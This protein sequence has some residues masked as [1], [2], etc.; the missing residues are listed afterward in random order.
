MQSV[1]FVSLCKLIQS[2]FELIELINPATQFGVS[3]K[4][5]SRIV[6][7]VVLSTHRRMATITSSCAF[8]V[9][10]QLLP[11]GLGLGTVFP[12]DASQLFDLQFTFLEIECFEKPKRDGLF[13]GR[14]EFVFV[15]RFARLLDSASESPSKM[16]RVRDAEKWITNW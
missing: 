2:S 10:N 11:I 3:S 5:C 1:V 15:F 13:L 16:V 9:R 8:G 12:F 14:R 7:H 6:Q 4:S